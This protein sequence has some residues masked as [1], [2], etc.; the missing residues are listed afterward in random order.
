M[1]DAW[2]Y[3]IDALGRKAMGDT[4]EDIGLLHTGSGIVDAWR[5]QDH[6]PFSAD[7]GL[8]VINLASA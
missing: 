7:F 3:K 2:C 1:L 6:N 8:D 5:V 4:C